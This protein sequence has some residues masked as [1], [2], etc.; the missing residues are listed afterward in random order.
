MEDSL[1]AYMT[2]IARMTRNHRDIRLGVSPRG[3]MALS[4]MTKAHALMM[5]RDYATPDDVTAV[6]L[7]TLGHRISLS[8]DA[9][10]S[11]KTAESILTSILEELPLPSLKEE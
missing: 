1:Y 10:Y 9:A 7:S 6:A 2:D 3:T 8:G 5:G 11:G 4:S